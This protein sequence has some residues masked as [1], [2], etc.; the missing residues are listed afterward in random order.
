LKGGVAVLTPE[1]NATP[2]YIS[3]MGLSRTVYEINSDLSRKIANF[4][5]LR[6]FWAPPWNLVSAL[7]IQKLKRWAT[8]LRKKFDDIFSRLDT[9]HERDRQMDE[10]TDGHRG[11]RA[12]AKTAACA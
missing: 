12:T 4:A 9:K 8:G 11:D 6:V 5:H 10:H 1:K 3:I 7:R 2:Y